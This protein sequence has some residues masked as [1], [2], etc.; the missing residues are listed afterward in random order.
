[1][2]APTA[3]RYFDRINNLV[4][5]VR[6]KAAINLDD[7][8]ID[9]ITLFPDEVIAKQA[10]NALNRAALAMLNPQPANRDEASFVISLLENLARNANFTRLA[11]EDAARALGGDD[12]AKW[13]EIIRQHQTE[14]GSLAGERATNALAAWQ[15]TQEDEGEDESDYN[16][17]IVHEKMIQDAQELG[18]AFR[19]RYPRVMREQH[20][21][22]PRPLYEFPRFKVG[23]IENEQMAEETRLREQFATAQHSRKVA[24]WVITPQWT[25]VVYTES[26]TLVVARLVSTNPHINGHKWSVSGN[27]NEDI[28]TRFK[29]DVEAYAEQARR[30]PLAFTEQHGGM[31][32]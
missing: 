29:R 11:N 7:A 32:A 5:D 8:N 23:E 17:D 14:R 26:R 6:A 30:D 22:D 19:P 28:I 18:I 25:I 4:A 13:A 12:M 20:P 15:A 1:M 24:P 3:K 10:Q 31:D 9:T 16:H 27:L 21:D 2:T